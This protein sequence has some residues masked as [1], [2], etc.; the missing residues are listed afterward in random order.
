MRPPL[1]KLVVVFLIGSILTS[2]LA[3]GLSSLIGQKNGPASAVNQPG[4]GSVPTIYR[5]YGAGPDGQNLTN[6]VAG[7][8]ARQ[9]VAT[10]PEG[11]IQLDDGSFNLLSPSSSEMFAFIAANQPPTDALTPPID[12]SRIRVMENFDVSDVSHYL[13]EII[14]IQNDLTS[15]PL[16]QSG[17]AATEGSPVTAN[18]ASGISASLA[19]SRESMYA[20]KV[21]TPFIP[22]QRSLLSFLSTITSFTEISVGDPVAAMALSKQLDTV[23]A[24][25]TAEMDKAVRSIT[26]EYPELLSAFPQ[27]RTSVLAQ[28]LGVQ[29]AHATLVE[30]VYQWFLT[31]Y[32]WAK[33]FWYRYEEIIKATA[34]GVLKNFLV[35]K[36]G[37]Q[38]IK[39]AEGEGIP[40]Y[41]TNWLVFE[42][43]AA[44]S[45]KFGLVS[46]EAAKA[47]GNIATAGLYGDI[48]S[49]AL[50]VT[51]WQAG[52]YGV[53]EATYCPPVSS[54]FYNRGGYVEENF[55]NSLQYNVY[56][57]L[58]DL[59]DRSLQA[60]GAASQ[61]AVNE[62]LSGRGSLDVKKCDDGTP[63]DNEGLCGDGSPA[64]TVTPGSAKQDLISKV[65]S[66]PQDIITAAN[67]E[68]FYV[69]VAQALTTAL[70]SKIL[71]QGE[72][73]FRGSIT[74][75]PPPPPPPPGSNIQ[76]QIA[77]YISQ[78]DKALTLTQGAIANLNQAKTTFQTLLNTGSCAEEL[79]LEIQQYM[80]EIDA[81]L[82]QLN[83]RLA[84][85]QGLLAQVKQ[86]QQ[87]LVPTQAE[88]DAIA[89][90]AEITQL[91][92]QAQADYDAANEVLLAAND[93][94]LNCQP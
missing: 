86:L 6:E 32:N 51:N 50:G 65:L 12:D 3:L 7:I 17:L 75:N 28:M 68:N 33:E 66:G 82:V 21:P 39:W 80:S 70:V 14:Q 58:L 5:L 54:G 85:I 22:F 9:L 91:A 16:W 92:A 73:L 25:Q 2:S 40:G 84:E 87:D 59:K 62:A 47:C 36:L 37:E 18:W 8:Y 74:G 56:N 41:V 27:E 42:A 43:D 76:Q 48:L 19:A 60:A 4:P 44:L 69:A 15:D 30:D 57:D 79:F 34:L 31:A 10:N 67:N 11:P 81:L 93:L 13:N 29:I 23:I 38:V 53:N 20:L 26:T 90:T 1:K 61:A 94:F 63:I 64:R 55:L 89:S 49:S 45:A 35:Q 88:L 24:R 52:V 83:A 78:L 46:R 72:G 71:Q 77:W